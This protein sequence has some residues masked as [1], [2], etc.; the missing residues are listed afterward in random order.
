[1]PDAS[2]GD[3]AL[4]FIM[5][6]TLPMLAIALLKAALTLSVAGLWGGDISFYLLPAVLVAALAS[7]LFI[8]F[9]LL[10][11]SLMSD[12]AVGGVCGALLTNFATWLSGVFLPIDLIGGAFKTVTEVLPFYHSAEAIRKVL[13]G[14]Y[15]EAVPHLA[16]VLGYT[17]VIFVIAVVAFKRKMNGLAESLICG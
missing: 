10:S 8:G 16:I 4:D 13:G 7:P 2:C 11:G 1:M 9:G 17:V 15:S 12:K 6:Y 14:S 5:G 3:T